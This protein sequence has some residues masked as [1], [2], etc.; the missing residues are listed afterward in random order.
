[1]KYR[2]TPSLVL[3]FLAVMTGI[4][5][6]TCTAKHTKGSKSSNSH[7]KSLRY[8]SDLP[9][10]TGVD[11]VISTTTDS[12]AIIPLELLRKYT[13]TSPTTPPYVVGFEDMDPGGRVDVVTAPPMPCS[14]STNFSNSPYW[15]N[16]QGQQLIRAQTHGMCVQDDSS[17]PEYYYIK[18]VGT[19]FRA[20]TG[21]CT[22]LRVSRHA[23]GT[24]TEYQTPSMKTNGNA[25]EW[26]YEDEDVGMRFK[27]S[28]CPDTIDDTNIVKIVTTTFG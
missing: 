14:N 28:L 8:V 3:F 21:V 18:F 26:V 27:Y 10:C 9:L 17:D 25:I 5:T 23:P 2:T 11:P 13:G 20:T 19:N 1:M 24:L 15:C 4:I 12:S 22:L 6:S 7:S 16:T